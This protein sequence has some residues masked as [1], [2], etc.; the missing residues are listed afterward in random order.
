MAE[1]A[2]ASLLGLIIGAILM[3]IWGFNPFEAYLALFQGAFGDRYAITTTLADATPLILTGL[4]FAI[5]VR[6]G[7][8]NIGA[9]GQ[10]LVGAAAAV[11]ASLFTLPPG[12]HILVAL[13]FGM[14]AGAVW[15]L[16]ASILKITR[17]V[18]EVISTIMLNWVAWFFALYAISNLLVDPSRAEKSIS[19]VPSSRFPLL[20]QGSDLSAAIFASVVFAIIIYFILWHLPRGYEIRGVGLNPDA[21][22]YA[23]VSQWTTTNLAFVLGGFAAGLAGATQV[24]GRPPTFALFGDLSNLANLGFDGIAVALIGRNHPIGILFSA[25]FF[26]ALTTGARLM[27][28]QAGVPLEMVRA[29]Q[30]AIIIAVAI[31][32]LLGLFNRLRRRSRRGTEG[33]EAKAEATEEAET[34]RG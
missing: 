33:A 19:I 15:S 4:T 23:G 9:Q 16:P 30:G 12:I 29:V 18:H 14:I 20:M 1:V 25:V 2:V 28:I 26:G 32:E 17:G 13:A 11:S 21:S 22:R 6:A 3:A 7:L 27:Q 8:F 5:G 10:M 34:I 31:P 24:L